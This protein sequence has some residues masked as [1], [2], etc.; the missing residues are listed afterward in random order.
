[1]LN[2]SIGD[3]EFQKIY[4]TERQTE[5]HRSVYFHKWIQCTVNQQPRNH[6]TMNFL[7]WCSCRIITNPFCS[8][9]WITHSTIPKG[10]K[11]FS[12]ATV[13]LMTLPHHVPA[14]LF[15]SDTPGSFPQNHNPFLL[16]QNNT[17]SC[18]LWGLVAL[19]H[20]RSVWLCCR[21]Q[22]K[23]TQNSD[24]IIKGERDDEDRL[25]L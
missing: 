17:I 24:A 4:V 2:Y 22:Y 5:I 10:A 16:K 20:M 9:Q 14:E 12:N 21:D 23:C 13:C 8:T 19:N 1:M 3:S 6:L 18:K 7:P 25:P 15:W 11:S